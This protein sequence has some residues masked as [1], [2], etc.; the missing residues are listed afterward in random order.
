MTR[1]KNIRPRCVRKVV[2]NMESTNSFGCSRSVSHRS[3]V[4]QFQVGYSLRQHIQNWG[5]SVESAVLDRFLDIFGASNHSIESLSLIRSF[6]PVAVS[7][8]C[9]PFLLVDSLVFW[10]PKI[11]A[12]LIDH[13]SWLKPNFPVGSDLPGPK[14]SQDAAWNAV[15]VP[16]P[17]E[18]A[19]KK[20]ESYWD[21]C[22]CIFG[23][24]VGVWNPW[25][26]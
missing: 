11:P 15:A 7:R 18:K 6:L 20:D 3:V 17:A 22:G 12:V 23:G 26:L 14:R 9:F 21:P 2:T 5:S 24:A 8:V 4:T 25:L 19:G 16:S 10:M 1:R 13:F